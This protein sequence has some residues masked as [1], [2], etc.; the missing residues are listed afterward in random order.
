MSVIFRE[1]VAARQAVGAEMAATEP[2]DWLARCREYDS[3]CES[4]V[5]VCKRHWLFH[6]LTGGLT[7]RLYEV[8]PLCPVLWK[9]HPRN[10]LRRRP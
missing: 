3:I 6:G 7:G 1:H 4:C 8:G 9:Y 5:Y 2:L 10:P